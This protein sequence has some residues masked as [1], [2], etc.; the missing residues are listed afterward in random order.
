M[1][2]YT[3]TI[4]TLIKNKFDFQLTEYPIFDETYRETL[5]NKI[6]N[7][8]YENEIAFET[9]PLFRRYLKN[10]MNEIMPYYNSLYKIQKDIL[11]N[12]LSLYNVD[13]TEKRDLARNDTT[14]NK[15][16]IS[17]TNETTQSGNTS[18]NSDTTTNQTTTGKEIRQD[19]PQGKIYETDVDN[20]KWAT[21]ANL[22]RSNVTGTENIK[23]TSEDTS[24]S[25]SNGSQESTLNSVTNGTENYVKSIVGANGNKYKIEL[26][27]DVK[28][29][30]MNID[31]LIINDLSDLF[32]GIW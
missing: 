11:D 10:Q 28:N 6:L 2:H 23:N 22:T 29:N 9:A 16:N 32:L 27:Q 1:A 26:L 21:Q 19:T 17:N 12:D 5:N 31:L 14:D 18:S 8:Y 3:I 7:H 15:N 4:K 25:K 30:I 20:A 13:L 24:S